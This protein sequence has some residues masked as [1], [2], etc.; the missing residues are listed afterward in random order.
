[1]EW[2]PAAPLRR[3][4][5]RALAR[6][7]VPSAQARELAEALLE[8]SR[9]GVDTPEHP[10][11]HATGTKPEETSGLQVP[12]VIRPDPHRGVGT[13]NRVGSLRRRYC[14]W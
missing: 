5:T 13:G 12:R 1:M 8:T 14:A 11:L 6:R 4:M 7:G 2:V 3:L 10:E 9:R